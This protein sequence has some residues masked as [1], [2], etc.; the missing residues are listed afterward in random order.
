[1]KIKK[2][3]VNTQGKKL[4]IFSLI[5]IL[6]ISFIS[7]FGIVSPYWKGN[8]L[9]IAPGDTSIVNLKIQNL[10]TTKDITLRALIKEGSEIASIRKIDYIIK[11]E[12]KDTVIPIIIK[13]PSNISINY[14][15]TV[16]VS[17]ITKNSDPGSIFL[18]TGIDTSFDVL[19]ADIPKTEKK[20]EKF[21]LIMVFLILISIFIFRKNKFKFFKNH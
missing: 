4:I 13:T 11:A 7:S 10:G 14:K 2:I 5:V 1:M 15:Y 9:H 12:T 19:I 20:G 18:G 3:N 6:L 17:F 21:S 8:P 16:T